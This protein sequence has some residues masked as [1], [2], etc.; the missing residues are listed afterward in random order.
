MIP[1]DS[2]VR[3][4]TKGD[5]T[6]SKIQYDGYGKWVDLHL[7]SG[8]AYR[9]DVSFLVASIVRALDEQDPRVALLTVSGVLR[10]GGKDDGEV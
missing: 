10:W 7:S 2:D 1:E 3:P 4:W 5:V 9:L 8:P 6:L